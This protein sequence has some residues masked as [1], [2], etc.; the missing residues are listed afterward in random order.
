MKLFSI[1][2]TGKKKNYSF[3]LSFIFFNS[4]VANSDTHGCVYVISNT[5]L[6]QHC[7][8]VSLYL[9]SYTFHFVGDT[10]MT[11]WL[12]D[13]KGSLEFSSVCVSICNT[14]FSRWTHFSFQIFC[15]KWGSINR[16]QLLRKI[17]D[18]P[19]IG[20]FHSI[21]VPKINIIDFFSK[22]VP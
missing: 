10:I 17:L 3:V 22:C 2:Y 4:F 7:I 5:L 14:V 21:F 9:I 15:M 19:K 11:L 13:P 6:L 8:F 16:S 20:N 12:L 1:H 18:I